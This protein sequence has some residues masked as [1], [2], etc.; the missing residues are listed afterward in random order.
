MGSIFL[1]ARVRCAAGMCSSRHYPLMGPLVV[2]VTT[3]VFYF[4]LLKSSLDR[5]LGLPCP[6]SG[7]KEKEQFVFVL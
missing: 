3:I 6:C 2:M 7:S 1:P 4:P 5:A